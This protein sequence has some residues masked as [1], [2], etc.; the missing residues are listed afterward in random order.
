MVHWSQD[1]RNNIGD[2]FH[3]P[4]TLNSKGNKMFGAHELG[5]DC[6]LFNKLLELSISL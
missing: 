4:V 6:A 3:S 5:D 1:K 2:F